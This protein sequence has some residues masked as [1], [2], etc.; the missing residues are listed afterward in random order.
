MN[1]ILPY[2]LD[3]LSD[4]FFHYLTLLLS[5][6]KDHMQMVRRFIEATLEHS[7]HFSDLHDPAH[8]LP[9]GRNVL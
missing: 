7:P 8:T 6:C 3:T 2:S 9:V 4:Y 1:T 5:E